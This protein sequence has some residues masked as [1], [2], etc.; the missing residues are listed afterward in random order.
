MHQNQLISQTA[1]HL[2]SEEYLLSKIWSKKGTYINTEEDDLREVIDHAINGYKYELVM[3][4]LLEIEK[5]IKGVQDDESLS[6]ELKELLDRYMVY[7][8]F[9]IEISKVLGERIILKR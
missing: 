6:Q 7:T 5:G 4:I 8:Q 3:N 2:L 1:A 9:K